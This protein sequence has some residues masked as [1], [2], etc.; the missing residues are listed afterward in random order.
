M[1]MEKFTSDLQ[2][3]HAER[4]DNPCVEWGSPVDVVR[5][6]AIH[7]QAPFEISCKKLA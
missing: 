2:R 1:K 6:S 7:G 5:L 4:I 3:S